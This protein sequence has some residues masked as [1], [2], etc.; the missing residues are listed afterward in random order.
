MGKTLVAEKKTSVVYAIGA[1]KKTPVNGVDWA[2]VRP[3]ADGH[4]V[5][6]PWSGWTTPALFTSVNEAKQW[7]SENK[8]QLDRETMS[9]YYEMDTLCIKERAIIETICSTL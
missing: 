6:Q 8:S 1:K 3:L 2:Y 7:W 5:L 9:K 4:L